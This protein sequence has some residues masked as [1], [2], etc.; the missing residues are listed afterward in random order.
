MRRGRPRPSPRR[1]AIAALLLGVL[2]LALAGG[3]PDDGRG[4]APVVREAPMTF[5]ET[6]PPASGG[7]AR[8]PASLVFTSRRTG[9]AATTGGLHFVPRTGDIPARDA[10]RIQRTDDGGVTWRTLWSGRRVTLSSLSVAGTTIV[11]SGHRALRPRCCPA[12]KTT[13]RALVVVSDDRGLT[14]S[15][16]IAPPGGG[17]VEA[18]SPR[19]WVA[20][21]QGEVYT[22]RPATLARTEDAGRHWRRIAVPRR[23][24]LVRFASRSVGFA[25]APATGCARK[26]QL[27]RTADGG[28]TWT[29]VAGTCGDPL[30]DLDVVSAR[31]LF[32]AH[33]GSWSKGRR[34]GVVRRSDDGGLTW[35]TIRRDPYQGILGLAFAD[36]RH[37]F[38]VVDQGHAEGYRYHRWLRASSDGGRTWADRPEVPTAFAGPRHAWAGDDGAGIVWR[39][40]DGGR[41]WRMSADPR[42]LAPSEPTLGGDHGQVTVRTAA[43]PATTRDGGRTWQLARFPPAPATAV[44]ERRGADVDERCL[45]PTP[46]FC[47]R[48][49]HVVRVTPDGGRTWTP[50]P[51]PPGLRKD[52]VAEAAFT[53]A[54]DGLVAGGELGFADSAVFSTHDAGR[55]WRRVPVPEDVG[56]WTWSTLA[57]GVVVVAPD[58][59]VLV[60]VDEGAMWQSF[61]VRKGTDTCR[62]SRPSEADLWV[63][64]TNAYQRKRE[65][66][67]LTSRDG[68]RTWTRRTTRRTLGAGIAAVSGD[69]AWAANELWHDMP[70]AL[71]HTT[72]GGATW[73]RVWVTLDPDDPVP[74]VTSR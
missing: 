54:R 65:T 45:N 28:Q 59:R 13:G 21:R 8:G 74:Q 32:A 66:I 55:T 43:G 23:T 38:A 71:W 41:T 47:S 58:R 69:E 24:S 6:P 70:A 53:T 26:A 52:E 44:A 29:P 7:P 37:A 16:R 57:P 14:W 67:L 25:S 64:C 68:G 49:D 9:F 46:G 56:R 31:V 1:P 33:S 11:A 42:S 17:A 61:P 35:R 15:R 12:F 40:A 48:F 72:D 3:R 73:R 18:L 63:M 19:V 50:V 34:R 10:A 4:E 60:S 30:V 5:A 36:A 2:A 27:W 51:R 20:L 62:A 39:T 22:R